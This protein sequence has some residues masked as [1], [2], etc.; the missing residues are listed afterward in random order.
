MNLLAIV[1]LGGYP[2]FTPLYK[3]HGFTEDGRRM[4]DSRGKEPS[5]LIGMSRKA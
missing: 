1:E 3:K 5:V 4:E 2:D